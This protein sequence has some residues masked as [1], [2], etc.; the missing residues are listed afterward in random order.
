MYGVVDVLPN[1]QEE[2]VFLG[3]YLDDLGF[4]KISGERG[5]WEN[6][7]RMII[8]A[9]QKDGLSCDVVKKYHYN[10]KDKDGYFNLFIT[11]KIS[12]NESE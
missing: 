6:G 8:L 3:M 9:Y 12:C 4:E 11:E 7:P 10:E 2:Y 1:A 5:D